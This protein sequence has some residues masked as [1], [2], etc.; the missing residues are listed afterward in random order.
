MTSDAGGSS[1]TLC[2]SRRPDPPCSQPSESTALQR[3]A[4]LDLHDL[5]GPAALIFNPHSGQKFGLHTNVHRLNEVQTA[6]HAEGIPFNLWQTKGPGHATALARRAV[7]E[8]RKLVIAAG[9]TARSTK[10]RAAY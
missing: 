10:W 2:D 5:R 8:H 9:G 3:W 1:V 4:T 7:L 6:L